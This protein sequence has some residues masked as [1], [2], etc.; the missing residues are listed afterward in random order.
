M[1]KKTFLTFAFISLLTTFYG[2]NGDFR[3]ARRRTAG[4][5]IGS[6]DESRIAHIISS[7]TS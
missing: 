4:D 5:R 6:A 1:L 7:T 3:P 2:L